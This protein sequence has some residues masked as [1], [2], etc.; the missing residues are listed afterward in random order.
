MINKSFIVSIM[1]GLAV[2]LSGFSQGPNHDCEEFDLNSITYIED[3]NEFDLGFNTEDY[4]PLDFDPH[5][6]YVDLSNIEF[7]E[8]DVLNLNLENY[9]PAD[10]NAYAFPGYFRSIDYIDPSDN[11]SLDFNT[12]DYLPK[13]FNP[14]ARTIDSNIVSL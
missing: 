2:I 12:A 6:L 4:L 7:V 13:G 9:L 8:E 14:Y 11:F 5:T 10:F 3:E 1:M